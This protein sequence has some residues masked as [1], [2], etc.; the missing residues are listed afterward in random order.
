MSTLPPREAASEGP[1]LRSL[2][3]AEPGEK[4]AAGPR[5]H[6]AFFFQSKV[7]AC[8]EDSAVW[9]SRSFQPG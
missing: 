1:R 5:P 9:P 4:L 3:Q 7:A 6:P 8:I 2:A